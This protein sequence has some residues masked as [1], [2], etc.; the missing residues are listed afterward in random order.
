MSETESPSTDGAQPPAPEAPSTPAPEPTT[1]P[2]PGSAP[3]S[4]PAPAAL[5]EVASPADASTPTSESAASAGEP[6]PGRDRGGRAQ[7]DHPPKQRRKRT[8]KPSGEGGSDGPRRSPTELLTEALQRFRNAYLDIRSR[9][10]GG[11]L[12]ESG[13]TDSV[14]LVLSVPL[15]TSNIGAAADKLVRDLRGGLEK[16]VLEAGM[17]VPGR[18]WCFSTA[19]FDSDYSRPEDPRQVL[20]GYGLEGRPRYADLVTLAIERKHESVDEL[21]AGKEG[22]VSF[23][24]AGAAVTEGVKPAFD[25]DAIP[26]RLVAQ[27]IAGLF[28]SA[29]EGRRVALTIQVLAHDGEDGKLRLVVH[30]VSAV[31]LMDLPDPN[32]RRI[33]RSFQTNLIQIAK[34]IDGE[35]AAGKEVDVTEAVLGPL[36]ELT[37]QMS[38]DARNRERKT[39]HARERGGEGDRPTQLAFPEARSAHDHHLYIDNEEQTVVVIG[40]KGRVHVFSP[41]GRHVTTVVMPPANVRQRVSAGRWRPAEPPER[42]AF[43]DAIAGKKE[44]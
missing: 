14:E 32:L 28:A 26:H 10:G 24:E 34:T 29:E 18:A 12:T 40:K 4:V 2:A 27:S 33:L 9:A 43:R 8:K 7:G 42:G 39:T 38:A 35:R 23:V 31:D 22:A 30:P 16:R 44:S 21:L 13:N 25:P 37:R 3:E 5:E 11:R 41:D 6:R 19:S 36:R 20:V 15:V 1:T 17:L